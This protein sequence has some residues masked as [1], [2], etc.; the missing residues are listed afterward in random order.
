[1]GTRVQCKSYIS[2]YHPI[3]DLNEDPAFRWSPF[4]EDKTFSGQ[5][6]NDLKSRR[7]GSWLDYNK[8]MLK[9]IML[10]HEAIFQKQVCE[11]HRLYRIQK[12]LMHEHKKNQMSRFYGPLEASNSSM[13]QSQMLPDFGESKW[14]LPHGT[15]ENPFRGMKNGT[16]NDGKDAS[17]NF[18]NE[19]ATQCGS[20]STK[21]RDDKDDIPQD[22]ELKKFPKRMLD[23]RL[24]A[25]AYIENDD[26]ERIER[27]NFI[28]SCAMA[29]ETHNMISGIES[30]NDVKLTLNNAKAS[31]SGKGI[32]KSNL[33]DLN[34]PCKDLCEEGILAW[35]SH[36][37][38]NYNVCSVEVQQLSKS[39]F[40]QRNF[41]IDQCRDGVTLNCHGIDKAERGREWLPLHSDS[42]QSETAGNPFNSSLFTE[43][44]PMSSESIKLKLDKARD[45]NQTEMSL[46]EKTTHCSAMKSRFDKAQAQNQTE[47]LL[48]A[49]AAHCSELSGSLNFFNPN[50]PANAASHVTSPFSA[51]YAAATSPLTSWRNQSNGTNHIPI[52]VGANGSLLNEQNNS[53]GVNKQNNSTDFHRV[54]CKGDLQSQIRLGSEPF[55]HPNSHHGIQTCS[56]LT[57][58]HHSPTDLE[59]K[60]IT[61]NG[62]ASTYQNNEIHETQKCSRDLL[63][64]GAKYAKDLNLKLEDI[65]GFQNGCADKHNQ[66]KKYNESSTGVIWFGETQSCN[67]LA[68]FDNQLHL[69]FTQDCSLPPKFPGEEVKDNGS[70]GKHSFSSFDIIKERRLHVNILTD[71]LNS[72]GVLNGSGNCQSNPY[73][74]RSVSYDGESLADGPKG[75]GNEAV[76]SQGLRQDINLNSDFVPM[77]NNSFG[78]SATDK[79]SIPSSVSL[80]R[81][82]GKLTRKFDLEAPADEIEEDNALSGVEIVD[83]NHPAKLVEISQEKISSHDSSIK[84]AA[85]I[86]LS[87]SVNVHNHVDKNVFLSSSDS[88]NLLAEVVMS[89]TETVGVSKRSTC[90]GSEASNNDDG[91]DLFELMT[92]KL[93]ELKVDEY[94][95]KPY[96]KEKLKDDEKS[97]ASLLFTRPRRGQA[98]KRRQKKDF[99]KDVLPAIASLS[100]HEVTEDLQALGGVTRAAKSR[101]TASTRR[102]TS[103]NR[104]SPRGRRR[105]RSLAITIAEVDDNPPQIQAIHAELENDG[106]NIMTW[107]RTTRRCR[108]QRVPLGHAVAPQE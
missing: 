61:S 9:Q 22:T 104:S 103:Q 56:S 35:G 4:F 16:Y 68:E 45:Q 97:I 32:S 73:C 108:R 20:I 64:L 30:E 7:V 70:S 18:Q 36:E 8:E 52:A 101:Q 57:G 94:C 14:H 85:D 54:E 11:L 86:M 105:P 49:K 60:N 58:I 43:K 96:Q 84:L 99:Q 17:L 10:E 72:N 29:G 93:E 65:V 88:L 39:N 26:T 23:L 74:S 53:Y 87:M 2:G 50:H 15:L 24:P 38:S 27:K 21:I 42:C 91:M 34:E 100:R 83:M 33:A 77:D 82:E 25:E 5:L 48:G 95:C 78:V 67:G 40:P 98:R 66:T 102:S 80:S 37:Y 47:T 41:F 28:E 13:C 76:R 19:G 106:G 51:S 107:G 75:H 6:C 46:G 12:E 92:L 79:T 59:K 71:S 55:A 81:V 1:M 62:N 89:N 90:Y 69:R 31:L 63:F 3:R 44:Y